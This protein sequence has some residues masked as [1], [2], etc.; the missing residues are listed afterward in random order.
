MRW[1]ILSLL[2]LTRISLG[3]QFQTM[4][5]VSTS[6]IT[7]FGLNYTEIGSL[8][9]LF[10]LPGMVLSIP[11][12]YAGGLRSDRFM[13]GAGLLI[14]G[15]GGVIASIAEGFQLLATGRAIC[16][17][18]FVVST[19]FFAKLVAD[20]FSGKELA[21]ALSALVMSWP[22]GIAMGQIS[23]GWIAIN[24]DWRLAFII[25]SVYCG[26]SAVIVILF[27][28][29]PPTTPKTKQRFK[30][31]LTRH[32]IYLLI[33]ASMVWGFFNGGYL[34]Y[35]SF[36]PRVL[37]TAGYD[38]VSA[39][40]VISLASWVMI[41]SGIIC[42]Y[43]VD[44][45]KKPDLVL[46]ICLVGAILALIALF[47]S[48]LSVFS[49]LLFGVVGIA[50]AGVIVALSVQAVKPENRAV[51]IGIFFTGQFLLQASAPP[52]AGWLFDLSFNETWPIIFAM[53]LFL[54][55]ALANLLFRYLQKRSTI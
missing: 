52:V 1:F 26:I 25:A 51:G 37:V 11:V 46:Y 8:I 14:L 29:E 41:F 53:F 36:A 43:I 44:R 4:G 27:C 28:R 50:P 34:V 17:I 2:F 49:S 12:G 10:M 15:L 24:Y 20:W 23:H 5:S 21:T 45:T 30:F 33:V 18:G 55:T 16:G 19:I 54:F 39:L 47:A 40:T 32:E 9:G 3:F 22:F 48:G 6:L 42:G 31:F 13:I 35:L 7:D 38:V